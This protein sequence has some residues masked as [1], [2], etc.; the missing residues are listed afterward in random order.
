MMFEFI[1]RIELW[2]LFGAA[3][4]FNLT[5]GGSDFENIS[6]QLTAV[7]LLVLLVVPKVKKEKFV[8]GATFIGSGLRIFLFVQL[9]QYGWLE[10][11]AM[12]GA[13][14][15]AIAISSVFDGVGKH[16]AIKSVPQLITMTAVLLFVYFGMQLAD[17][18]NY[19]AGALLCVLPLS[20]KLNIIDKEVA[21]VPA[22]ISGFIIGW[23]VNEQSMF[24]VVN[25]HAF[26][27][28][29]IL[30]CSVSFK[31]FVFSGPMLLFGILLGHFYCQR[32]QIIWLFIALV[33]WQI[34]SMLMPKQGDRL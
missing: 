27:L 12:Q 23:Y 26:T 34:K 29:V 25:N 21:K 32:E 3:T 2:L 31:Q 14:I 7:G 13:T 5:I 18:F 22:I 30:I 4:V 28:S 17:G 16:I 10:H 33:L 19:A 8:D 9:Q 15:L 24:G 1:R 6:G 20:L 11:S